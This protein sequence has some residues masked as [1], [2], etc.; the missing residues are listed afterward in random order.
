MYS[1]SSL[2]DEMIRQSQGMG[3]ENFI[4][5]NCQ[6]YNGAI[7]CKKNVFIAF[8]PANMSGCRYFIRGRKCPHC[9]KVI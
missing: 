5:E 7:S 9:G 6:N 2:H 4:C 1:Q 8:V 3:Q